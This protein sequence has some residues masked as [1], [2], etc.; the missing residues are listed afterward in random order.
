MSTGS[1]GSSPR[2]RGTQWHPDLGTH[3]KRFIPA[4]AG[5]TT[6]NGTLISQTPVH[7]RERGEHLPYL[8]PISS[9]TGSSP[10]ARGTRENLDQ[11]FARERFIPASAGNTSYG[12]KHPKPGA[13]HPR[14]RGEHTGDEKPNM[15]GNGSS[16]R[17]RGTLHLFNDFLLGFRFIPASAGNTWKGIAGVTTHAVHPRERGEHLPSPS[18]SPS[19]GGSSP[20]ARGTRQEPDQ[21]D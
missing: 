6:V 19:S 8:F 13:V 15:V 1:G 20:R 4:S 18:P 7:P 17:A 10:R 14:E 9:T 5:N 11:D 16:P 3:P 12:R 2:A 21:T